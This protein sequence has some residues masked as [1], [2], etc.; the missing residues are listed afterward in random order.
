MKKF[1]IEV[2]IISKHNVAQ[3]KRVC[4]TG[5]A[6]Y[7]YSTREEAEHMRRLCYDA[8]PTKARV[9]EVES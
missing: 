5:G 4:P 8:D 1:G 7:V 3:W 6:P 2:L 9:V